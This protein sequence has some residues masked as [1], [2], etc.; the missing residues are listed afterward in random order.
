[1]PVELEVAVQL[2]IVPAEMVVADI[3]H[4]SVAAAAAQADRHQ[5]DLPEEI[6][7]HIM[8]QIV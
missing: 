2:Q 1:M 8:E 5:M 6:L 7:P 3:S 4:T